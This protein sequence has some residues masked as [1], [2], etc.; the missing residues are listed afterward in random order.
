MILNAIKLKSCYE[1]VL[2]KVIEYNV[3]SIALC[4]I[5]TG[6]FKYPSKDAARIAF[7]TVIS[8]LENNHESV[9]KITFC[10]YEN[11]DMEII[12]WDMSKTL[13]FLVIHF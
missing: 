2:Q 7:E 13:K 10:T 12:S 8:W 11:E 1:S 4:C 6:V 5:S 9:E 3:K